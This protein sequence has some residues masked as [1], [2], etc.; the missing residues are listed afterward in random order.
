MFQV[1]IPPP[2]L[3]PGIAIIGSEDP[4]TG[5]REV[6]GTCPVMIDKS[7]V[8]ASLGGARAGYTRQ[9]AARFGDVNWGASNN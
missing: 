7:T 6:L 5:E 3:V 9:Y 2:Q 4:V 8:N 1:Q